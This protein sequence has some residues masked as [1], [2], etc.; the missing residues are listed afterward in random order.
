MTTISLGY[1]RNALHA[2]CAS[3]VARVLDAHEA[4]VEFVDADPGELPGLLDEGAIDL[5]VSAWLPRDADLVQH[6]MRVLGTIYRPYYC[7]GSYEAVS[8]AAE[9]S[10]DSLDALFVARS[11]AEKLQ[12]VL[13]QT[14]NLSGLTPTIC[15]DEALFGTVQGAREA[16]RKF[17]VFLAQPH[18][19]FHDEAFQPVSD[20][21]FSEEMEAALLVRES[22]AA[23]A[24]QDMLDELSEMTLGNKVMSAL[25]YAIQVDNMDPEEAAE[26]W[27]RGR[28]VAR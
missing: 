25:E 19:L 16:G 11:D 13:A 22:V 1:L 21:R 24:D 26:A 3:A 15:E 10:G 14:P 28:L 18:A 2:G 9:L 7:W 5:L 12:Q 27:Q 23:C 8:S 20:P 4:E 6:G 17:V